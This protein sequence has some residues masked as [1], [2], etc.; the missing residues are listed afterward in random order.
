MHTRHV[1]L[2]SVL[3]CLSSAIANAAPSSKADVVVLMDESGSM[4]G[5]QAWIPGTITSL[6]SGLF[7]AGLTE[8]NRYGLVGFGASSSTSPAPGR[9]RSISVGGGQFGT[10]AQFGTAAGG[11]VTNGSQEDGWAAI[12][13][14]N[15]Y[16]FA[17]TAA[18]NYILVTDE[19]RDNAITSLTFASILSSMTSTNTLLNAVV[20]ATF[21]CGDNSA[22]L[23][24]IGTTGYKVAAGGG[25]TTCTGA[26]FVSGAGATGANYVSLALDTG[27]G[28]W[29]LNILRSGGNNALSFTN[30]FID[31]KIGE[32]V[33]QP[34]A[35]IPEPETYVLLM[36]GLGVVGYTARRRNHVGG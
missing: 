6:D 3:V 23:G 33:T 19:D 32:I 11:L 34:P 36:L 28:A 17:P 9:V 20:N 30:A 31:G 5:E 24:I 8:G 27:G 18:R 22:A 10:P 25:F 1:T 13:L 21:K 15:T 26:T 16:S 29:N 4:A 7:G 35:A 2:V 14:A 12:T